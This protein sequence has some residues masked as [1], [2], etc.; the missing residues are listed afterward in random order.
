MGILSSTLTVKKMAIYCNQLSVGLNAGVPI[1][2]T[3]E[4]MCGPGAPGRIKRINRDLIACIRRGATL[5]QAIHWKRRCFPD[6]FVGLMGVGDEQSGKLEEA[7]RHI[8]Q[9]HYATIKF[10]ARTGLL[11]L[12]GFLIILIGLWICHPV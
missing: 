12:E 2:Q 8:A 4:T 9:D 11:A 1:L 7:F 5:S 3:L 6:L 10:R